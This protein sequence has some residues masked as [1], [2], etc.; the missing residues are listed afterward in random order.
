MVALSKIA[1]AAPTSWRLMYIEKHGRP[2][3]EAAVDS[4]DVETR[5]LAGEC[6]N[7]LAE[8]GVY[9]FRDLWDRLKELEGEGAV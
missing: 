7:K 5:E 2:I 3:L 9:E 1:S 6:I 8:L 4:G